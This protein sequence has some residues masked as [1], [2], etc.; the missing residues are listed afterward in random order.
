[1]AWYF[2]VLLILAYFLVG[3]FIAGFMHRF[4]FFDDDDLDAMWIFFWPIVAPVCLF[5]SLCI[6][7]YNFARGNK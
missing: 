2:I 7:I 4:K 1:M 5:I 3:V 6:C